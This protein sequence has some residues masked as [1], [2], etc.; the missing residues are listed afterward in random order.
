M[1]KIEVPTDTPT[2]F[3]LGD[4][5]ADIQKKREVKKQRER[6]GGGRTELTEGSEEREEAIREEPTR[7][8][9]EG[10]AENHARTDRSDT[11]MDTDG[12]GKAST[13]QLSSDLILTPSDS[14]FISNVIRTS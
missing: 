2:E 6:E 11:E 5:A 8:A 3:K 14:S 9:E 7:S 4:T 12:G 1:R 10:V 13:S